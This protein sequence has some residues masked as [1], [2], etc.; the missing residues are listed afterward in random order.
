LFPFFPPGSFFQVFIHFI[1]AGA[2]I[3]DKC[4]RVDYFCFFARSDEKSR[5]SVFGLP[6]EIKE[7]QISQWPTRDRLYLCHESFPLGTQTWKLFQET[8][9]PSFRMEVAEKTDSQKLWSL[10]YLLDY[11][12]RKSEFF[13]VA[14]SLERNTSQV[15]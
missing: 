1:F 15:G 3:I 7:T 6:H 8:S 12:G 10:Q 11:S 9:I 13:R 4:G 14:T 2:H 5:F